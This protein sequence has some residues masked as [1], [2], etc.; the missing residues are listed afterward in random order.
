MEHNFL[1]TE[2]LVMS[3]KHSLKFTIQVEALQIK[4]YSS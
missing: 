4:Y 1:W 2:A 3:N